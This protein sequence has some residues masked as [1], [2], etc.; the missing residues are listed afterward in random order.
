MTAL[1]ALR[2]LIVA[3]CHKLGDGFVASL[4]ENVPN[5]QHLNLRYLRR[6]TDESLYVIARKAKFLYSLDVSFCTKIS[7]EAIGSLLFSLPGLSELHL[8]NCTQVRC[9]GSRSGDMQSCVW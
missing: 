9:S 7:A 5:L 8:F 3:E 1:R 6:V 4:V 2:T